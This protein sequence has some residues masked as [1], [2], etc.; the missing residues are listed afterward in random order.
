MLYSINISE[1][2]ISIDLITVGV[3]VGHAESLILLPQK[4]WGNYYVE[5]KEKK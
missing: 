1:L 5:E 3:L 4:E 2:K